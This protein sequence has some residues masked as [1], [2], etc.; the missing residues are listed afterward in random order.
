MTNV[1]PLLAQAQGA[2]DD[3]T[4]APP[5][6]ERKTPPAGITTARFIGYV[7]LGKR[8]QE[9]NGK[10]KQP[11]LEALMF[12]EFNS[13]KHIDEF[14]K[15]GATVKRSTEYR[16]RAMPVYTGDKAGYAKL[17]RAMRQGRENITNMAQ[18]LGE[19]FLITVL[20]NT[21][22]K[23]GKSTVYANIRGEDGAWK[24]GPTVIE[25]P[26]TGNVTQVPVPPATLPYRLLLWSQPTKEQWDSLFIDGT[27]ERKKT[28][29]G[30]EVTEEVSN[31]WIQREVLK[32]LDLKESPLWDVLNGLDGLDLEADAADPEAQPE[33][34]NDTPAAEATETAK[35]APT[36]E[37]ATNVTKTSEKPAQQQETK[38]AAAP[39]PDPAAASS[40]NDVLAALG[41]A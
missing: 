23:D 1:N 5:K 24:V 10:P 4:K 40:A 19:G 8:P 15:D 18:M 7:E 3:H 21:V 30:K 11:A 9:Y 31:N 13:P 26:L 28:V 6:F 14:E 22:E 41:L 2:T 35:D 16:L 27:H 37:K 25:D 36:E 17:F 33:A 39:A 29:D 34:A 38:P 32:A 20:H 12:F